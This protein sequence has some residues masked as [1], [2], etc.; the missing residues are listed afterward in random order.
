MSHIRS[1]RF[2]LNEWMDLWYGIT[3]WF[4]N[5]YQVLVLCRRGEHQPMFGFGSATRLDTGEVTKWSDDHW[6]C[7]YCSTKLSKI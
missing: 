4:S 5:K 1:M 2:Y 3:G 6:S 7:M